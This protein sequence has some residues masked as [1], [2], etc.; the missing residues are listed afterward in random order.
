MSHIAAS[1]SLFIL[2]AKYWLF[3]DASYLAH[4]GWNV[5]IIVDIAKLLATDTN[6]KHWYKITC[7]ACSSPT[8]AID[9]V[10]RV[11]HCFYK[12]IVSSI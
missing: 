4:L 12:F 8:D 2:V 3:R 5:D 6:C 10:E 7:V 9:M 11:K 1:R